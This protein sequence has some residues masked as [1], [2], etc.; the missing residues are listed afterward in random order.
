M[1]ESEIIRLYEK[2]ACSGL[3]KNEAENNLKKIIRTIFGPI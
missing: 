2:C 3:D 1:K